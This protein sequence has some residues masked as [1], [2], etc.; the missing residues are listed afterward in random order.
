M[1]DIE[2]RLRAALDEPGLYLTEP[3]EVTPYG[4]DWTRKFSAQP[5]LVARPNSVEQVARLLRACDTHGIKVVPQGGNTSLVGGSVPRKGEIV[6]SLARLNAIE[7]FD[8]ASGTIRVQAGVVLETLHRY[9]AE[10]DQLFPVDLGARGSCQLGG[11]ASTNAG[12]VKVIRYGHVR[13]Q[14]R[15]IEAVLA[16]GTVVSGLN[17]L[18]KNNTGL[19]LKQLFI[20]SEGILGVITR[21][22]LQAHPRPAARHTALFGVENATAAVALL[23]DLRQGL[24]GLSSL[25][26]IRREAIELLCRHDE[27]AHRPFAA[28][29]PFLV[30]A[31]AETGAG[32]GEREGFLAALSAALEA[33]HAADAVIAESEVQAAALWKL[34]EGVTEAIGREGLTHKF[35][36]TVPPG[37]IPEILPA[38]DSIAQT[39]GG[40]LCLVYGHLGDGNLHVNMV[41]ERET[42]DEAFRAKGTPL[43]ERIYTL[44]AD[45]EGSISAEHGIGIMKRDYLGLCRTEEEIALMRRLKR[46]LDPNRILNPGVIFT[47]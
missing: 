39:V 20:G 21:L 19:D 10:R 37:R 28:S 7:E 14:I 23:E 44:V 32:G 47:D 46:T 5:A 12:G 9:L 4:I 17:K 2:T 1:T 18:R 25:E 26:M 38:L 29:Y 41:Q 11:M 36:V 30:L 40:V 8:S 34:R 22:V 42:S 45:A 43:A 33:G 3:D 15:G 6:L 24:P 27:T 35:D 31:E 13:D 16:D